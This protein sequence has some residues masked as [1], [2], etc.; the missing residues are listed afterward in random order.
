MNILFY[1]VLIE[2]IP[3]SLLIFGGIYDTKSSKYPDTKIGYR[4]SYSTKDKFSWE[5]SNKLAAKLYG[6]VG[7]LLFIINA[8]LM[9]MIGENS[10]AFIFIVNL[11]VAVLSRVM[12]DALLKKK[13]SNN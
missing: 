3:L 12:I 6:F 1:L 5:Y 9:L 8:V 10:L 4:N 7:T 2:I 11:F 13:F